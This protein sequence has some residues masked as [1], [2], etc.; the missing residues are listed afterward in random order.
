VIRRYDTRRKAGQRGSTMVEVMVSVLLFSIGVVGLLR[1][2]GTAV[3]DTGA[4]EYRATAATLA[5]TVIG[6]MW[7]D[8]NNLGAYVVTGAT[9]PELPNGTRTVTVA[10]NV[11]TVQIGWQAPGAT[12]PST[13]QVSATIVG[14]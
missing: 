10:G 9:V 13:H 11:V 6:Q 12:A 3:Q 7:V 4:L 2:L 1:V 8:R 5:D 14:N